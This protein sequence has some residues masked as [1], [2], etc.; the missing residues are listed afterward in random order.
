MKEILN[1]Q[2]KL[3]ELLG[4]APDFIKSHE[5][6]QPMFKQL[7]IVYEEFLNKSIARFKYYLLLETDSKRI[8]L[9]E[10]NI[11]QLK[12]MKNSPKLEG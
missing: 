6:L 5:L 8:G 2:E 10:K 11:E 12:N 4:D 7:N 9:L 1:K 3:I